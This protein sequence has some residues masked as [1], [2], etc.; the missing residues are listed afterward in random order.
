MTT[1][2]GTTTTTWLPTTTS[3]PEM[4]RGM[5]AAALVLPGQVFAGSAKN[6][7]LSKGDFF[8]TEEECIKLCAN[9]E[10]CGG[11]LYMIEYAYCEF[12]HKQTSDFEFVGEDQVEDAEKYTSFVLKPECMTKVAEIEAEEEVS[13]FGSINFNTS[14]VDCNNYYVLAILDNNSFNNNRNA[15]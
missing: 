4:C 9:M 1:T 7:R 8:G 11:F 2:T 6:G 13:G 5:N 3:L 15:L 12:R 10:N 14:S